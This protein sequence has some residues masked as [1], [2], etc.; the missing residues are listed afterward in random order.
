MQFKATQHFED[1][2]SAYR[3]VI[4]M[5]L[6][7]FGS[8]TIYDIQAENGNLILSAALDIT[9]KRLRQLQFQIVNEFKH[10]SDINFLRFINI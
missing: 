7:K 3:E 6:E 1:A 2:E 5:R 8:A 9:I 10:D 4:A